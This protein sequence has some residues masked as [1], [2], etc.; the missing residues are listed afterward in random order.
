M[1]S[2]YNR[3]YR[4]IQTIKADR[5]FAWEENNVYTSTLVWVGF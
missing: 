1:K 4:L 5:V 2:I 3:L